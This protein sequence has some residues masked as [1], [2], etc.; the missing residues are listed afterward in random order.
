MKNL[1]LV[2]TLSISQ[3]AVAECWTV[4]DLQ[5]VSARAAEGYSVAKDGYSGQR[6]EVTILD[7]RSSV[8]PSD[9]QCRKLSKTSIVCLDS[10]GER[11][12]VETWSVDPQTRTAF[13]TKARSGFGALD[14]ANLFVGRIVGA[15]AGR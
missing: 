3:F 15:C 6:F 13:H 10:T 14:G 8:S 5:G 7:Q 1:L 9:M 4:A 11:S 2:A 12:T